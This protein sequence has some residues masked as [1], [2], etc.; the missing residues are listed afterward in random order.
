[1]ADFNINDP[2]TFDISTGSF[3]GSYY[4][5]ISVNPSDPS[6]YKG[7]PFYTVTTSRLMSEDELLQRAQVISESTYRY[8]NQ[9]QTFEFEVV[10]ATA[11]A[12][13]V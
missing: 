10:G 11:K 12:G 1:M 6:T 4:Y 8:P 5:T 13:L 3:K 7:P 9:N 2:S